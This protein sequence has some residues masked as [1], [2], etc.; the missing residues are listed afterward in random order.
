MTEIFIFSVLCALA[1]TGILYIITIRFFS[2]V[3]ALMASMVVS[4]LLGT[5]LMFALISVA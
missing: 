4:S 3:A 2:E 1:L 5:G